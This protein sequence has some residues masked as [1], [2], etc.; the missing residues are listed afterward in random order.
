MKI[1]AKIDFIFNGKQCVFI[2]VEPKDLS[3][4]IKEILFELAQFSWLSKIS[5]EPI[6]NSFK[7]KADK[8]IKRL[9]EKLG[10]LDDNG[11]IKMVAGEYIVSTLSKKAIVNQL[12]HTDIPLMELL[13][14]K[15]VGNPG[16]DFYTED[17]INGNII[18]CGEAKFENGKNAYNESLKQSNTFIDKSKHVEDLSLI[19]RFTSEKS[20]ENLNK[21][22]FGSS[23][24]FSMKNSTDSN[25]LIEIIKKNKHF[26]ELIDKCIS[27]VF[28][29]VEI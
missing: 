1:T 20:Q 6:K 7:F 21:G 23:L 9:T 14:R 8:T 29:G 10:D 27:A 24:A 17:E 2:R 3:I 26:Q 16:F 11:D 13:G 12:S 19:E 15:V 25:Y 22:D 28:V 4:T 5:S 18:F